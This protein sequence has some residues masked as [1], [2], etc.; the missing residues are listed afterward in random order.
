M[1]EGFKGKSDKIR[2]QNILNLRIKKNNKNSQNNKKRI[3]VKN[4]N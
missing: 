2:N 3:W 4:A 1:A